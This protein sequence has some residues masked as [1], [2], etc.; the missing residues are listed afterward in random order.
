[1]STTPSTTYCVYVLGM[2][3]KFFQEKVAFVALRAA[4]KFATLQ[5]IRCC[6][7]GSA[8]MN[9][10]DRSGSQLHFVVTPQEYSYLAFIFSGVP[11]V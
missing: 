4:A 9:R 7:V 1:M 10:R 6:C 8:K 11:H 5:H 2:S 3:T